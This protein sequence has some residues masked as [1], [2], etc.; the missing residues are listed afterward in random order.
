MLKI[1]VLTSFGSGK[2]AAGA[3][4]SKNK[5]PGYTQI[6]IQLKKRQYHKQNSCTS[7][8]PSPSP[9]HSVKHLSQIC[10]LLPSET[11][12]LETLV[13]IFVCKIKVLGPRI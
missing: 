13:L 1:N 10:S 11:L 9:S 12:S 5:G 6:R 2:G 7:M 4:F 8:L 3:F